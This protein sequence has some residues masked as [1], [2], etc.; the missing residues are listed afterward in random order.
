MRALMESVRTSRTTLRRS[1]SRR[2]W[3]S[4]VQLLALTFAVGCAP[5]TDVLGPQPASGLWDP[6]ATMP[7]RRPDAD[8]VVPL[9]DAGSHPA[10]DA[11]GGLPDAAGN[12]SAPTPGG[13]GRPWSLSFTLTT[14]SHHGSYAP[15]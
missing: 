5:P 3:E 6:G 12:N 11:S 13:R 1:A 4:C 14:S 15:E 2:C 7:P 9:L 8:I 10:A